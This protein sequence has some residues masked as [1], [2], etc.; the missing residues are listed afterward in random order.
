[1]F[2]QEKP[3]FTWDKIKILKSKSANFNKINWLFFIST[4]TKSFSSFTWWRSSFSIN[5]IWNQPVQLPIK[6]N[7]PDYEIMEILISAVEKIVVR[8][9]VE[10][11]EEL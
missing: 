4:M 9:L 8:N 7:Q 3:Y 10:Y 5:V 11:V 6:N 1:M 2:Y